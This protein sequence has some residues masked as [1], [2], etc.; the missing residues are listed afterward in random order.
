M[1]RLC[2]GGATCGTDHADE[3]HDVLEGLR[4]FLIDCDLVVN[5]KLR[6]GGDFQMN[7]QYSDAFVAIDASAFLFGLSTPPRRTQ[8]GCFV[9]E[10]GITLDLLASP[11]NQMNDAIVIQLR[12]EPVRWTTS[13]CRID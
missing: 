10:P 4:G 13:D 2:Y 5:I 8:S 9:Q 3:G 6:S 7:E 11:K 1:N 12:N